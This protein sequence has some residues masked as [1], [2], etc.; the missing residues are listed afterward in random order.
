VSSAGT[1]APPP[2]APAVAPA[3]DGAPWCPVHAGGRPVQRPACPAP[4]LERRLRPC[5]ACGRN[6]YGSCSCWRPPGGQCWPGNRWM[7]RVPVGEI[8]PAGGAGLRW[9]TADASVTQDS[10]EESNDH[11]CTLVPRGSVGWCPH[12]LWQERFR[13]HCLTG[14]AVG[15]LRSGTTQDLVRLRKQ[16]WIRPQRLRR[17]IRPRFSRSSVM[18]PRQRKPQSRGFHQAR[19]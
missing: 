8:R 9:G 13:G 2:A 5:P 14:H 19:L 1:S 4:A 12:R 18:S 11:S 17:N 10:Y 16:P 15:I 6:L 7:R 3:S